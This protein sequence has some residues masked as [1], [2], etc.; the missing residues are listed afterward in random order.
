[1]TDKIWKP[2]DELKGAEL[3]TGWAW[4][5]KETLRELWNQTSL[6]SATQFWRQ[7]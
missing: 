6:A 4:D 5:I 7:A 1:M 3:E 2:F